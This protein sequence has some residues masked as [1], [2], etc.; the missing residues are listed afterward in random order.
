MVVTVWAVEHG[1]EAGIIV[2]NDFAL[3]DLFGGR[4][5][6]EKQLQKQGFSGVRNMRTME[7]AE[8]AKRRAIDKKLASWSGPWLTEYPWEVM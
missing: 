1:D 4:A 5:G 3:G 6:F 7:E 8:S 2:L